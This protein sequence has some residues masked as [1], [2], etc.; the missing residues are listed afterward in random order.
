DEIELGDEVTVSFVITNADSRPYVF[1]PF[2][3]IGTTMIMESVELEGHE[4]IT[5][6]H[7]IT[8]ENI[9]DY[10]VTID[11]LE[12]SF[13]VFITPEPPFWMQPGFASGILILIISAG[14]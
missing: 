5:I 7:T 2:V 3:Q 8:P 14:V 6:S 13:T 1:I 10:D 4:S 12:G 11:G 9:G